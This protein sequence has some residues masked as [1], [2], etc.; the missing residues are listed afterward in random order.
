MIEEKSVLLLFFFVVYL[1]F[2]WE[3][4]VENEGEGGLGFYNKGTKGEVD[5][6]KVVKGEGDC[7]MVHPVRRV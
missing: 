6:A 3:D 1:F 7:C 4:V 5:A 2:S